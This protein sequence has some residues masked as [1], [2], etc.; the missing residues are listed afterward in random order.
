MFNDDLGRFCLC[1]DHARWKWV[2]VFSLPS[3][4][5]L[6][7]FTDDAAYEAHPDSE[8]FLVVDAKPS[9]FDM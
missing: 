5:S 8:A 7:I 2:E 3:V 4:R 9:K 1:G 6:S